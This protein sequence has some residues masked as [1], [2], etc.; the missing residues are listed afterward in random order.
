MKSTLRRA[1]ARVS[2]RYA[3]AAALILAIGIPGVA[4][5]AGEGRSLIAGHR[6]PDRGGSLH[7]ETQIIADNGTYGTRQSN[8]RDGDGGG[9]IYGC[10]SDPGHEP[11]VRANNLKSGRAFEFETDG[12]EGGN[13]H[14]GDA[15]VPFTTNGTGKVENLNADR[16]DDKN[17]ADFAATGDLLFAAVA[18]D[19][20]LGAKRGAT[21]SA[22]A[23]A[24]AN[25][26]AV[27]F[28]RDVSAC[29]YTASAIGTADPDAAF[30]VS[31]NPANKNQVLVDQ[32]DD[33]AV[34]TSFHL[35]VIC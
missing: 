25:T 31:A 12:K 6:N 17:A 15:G 8:K 21:A 7:S 1:R 34:P 14:V 28:D 23:A 2:G 5:G 35:Q 18:D 24:A 33:P 10:R 9:A 22:I 26:Y 4:I 3:I 32:P 16:L 11:C 13:I 27:A 20:K 30:G 19:G 29:S